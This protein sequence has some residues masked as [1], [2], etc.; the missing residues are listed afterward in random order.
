MAVG[1]AP[2]QTPSLTRR[3]H[4]ASPAQRD[5]LQG[6]PHPRARSLGHK[7]EMPGAAGAPDG[8][9]DLGKRSRRSPIQQSPQWGRSGP[10]DAGTCAEAPGGAGAGDA[11]LA[12]ERRGP[13]EGR[14][15]QAQLAIR[16]E[17][18]PLP[19]DTG[20]G[21]KARRG[22]ASQGRARG[23]ERAKLEGYAAGLS[24][25]EPRRPPSKA[26]GTSR[27]PRVLAAGDT[28]VPSRQTGRG[29]SNPG[30]TRRTREVPRL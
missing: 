12:Q 21:T 30:K 8:D 6:P 5:W 26:V 18:R 13:P 16:P 17:P 29:I 20:S 15:G 28:V 14:G 19:T 3:G 2:T 4:P 23:W 25:Q 7:G 1:P 27:L 11:G 10:R 24:P 9:P 22:G